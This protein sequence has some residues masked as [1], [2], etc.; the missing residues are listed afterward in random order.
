MCPSFHTSKMT[1]THQ[2]QLIDHFCFLLVEFIFTCCDFNTQNTAEPST[3]QPASPSPPPPRRR[4]KP[5]NPWVL[6][7]IL[8]K[9]ER[10][11][12]RTLLDKL[13]TIDIPGYRNF[14]RMEPAFFYLI[15]ERITLT[16]GSK[17]PT[18]GGHLKSG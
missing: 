11:C 17:L 12:Y 8:Q 15:E 9:E 7:W 6:P 4:R 18:S 1:G 14:T 2:E 16:S 13:I 5:Q 3:C 10:G